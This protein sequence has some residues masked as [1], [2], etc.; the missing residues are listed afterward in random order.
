[1]SQITLE[2][3]LVTDEVQN[4]GEDSVLDAVRL[5]EQQRLRVDATATHFVVLLGHARIFADKL[6]VEFRDDGLIAVALESQCER[7]DIPWHR[8]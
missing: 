8:P 6:V 3:L 1:M 2:R 4:L 5:A 7:H